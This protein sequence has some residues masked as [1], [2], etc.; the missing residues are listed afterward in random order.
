MTESCTHRSLAKLATAGLVAGAMTALPVTVKIGSTSA[1]PRPDDATT[2]LAQGDAC[3]FAPLRAEAAAALE[4]PGGPCAARARLGLSEG[5]RYSSPV[6]LTLSRAAAD[7]GGGSGGGDSGGNSGP[8]GGGSGGGGSGGS[9]GNSGPGGGSGGGSGGGNSGPGGSG[10]SGVSGGSGAS[11]PSGAA[12]AGASA[13]SEG[14]GFGSVEQA[15]PDLS[16]DEE[17]A[18]IARGWQ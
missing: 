18:A 11:S 9:G 10:G 7:G 4:S 1:I 15:G 12:S 3:A 2:R 16:K 5:F 14:D 6:V 13:G 17:A 8:G